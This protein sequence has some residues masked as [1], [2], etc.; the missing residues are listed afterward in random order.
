MGDGKYYI[1]KDGSGKKHTVD[2]A[3]YDS[4][5]QG[6]AK[7]FPNARFE[8][9]DR[10]TG[11]RGD[12][13]VR[14]VHRLKDFGANLFTGRR[15]YPNSQSAQ[16]QQKKSTPLGRA[17]QS[18]AAEKWG[19]AENKPFWETG[20]KPYDASL[21]L[22]KP[23]G[24]KRGQKEQNG[25]LDEAAWDTGQKESELVRG[26]READA[27]AR[28]DNEQMP[29]DYTK[30]TAIKQMAGRTK[31]NQQ[32]LGRMM[33]SAGQM[34]ASA[35]TRRR[36]APAFDTGNDDVNNNIVKTR[37]QLEKEM[38]SSAANIADND[39]ADTFASMIA[40]E[41]R[42][43]E[44]RAWKAQM[45]AQAG[46]GNPM[47]TSIL[48]T[49][50][51]NAQRDPAKLQQNLSNT[52]AKNMESMLGDP[53]VVEKIMSESAR[54]GVSP[55]DYAKTALIPA[56][57]NK[58]MAEYDKSELKE[59]M[60]RNAF[61]DIID[62][63][64]DSF[65]GGALL[66]AMTTKA[67]RQYRQRAV[68]ATEEG[69]NPY[70]QRDKY[71]VT[72]ALRGGVGLMT[73]VLGP[74]GGVFGAIGKGV[75]AAGTRVFG[76]GV[77]AAA[78]MANM[79]RMQRAFS[80]PILARGA[81]EGAANFGLYE[82]AKGAQSYA[83][84]TDD[85]RLGEMLTQSAASAGHGAVS[86]ATLG[87]VGKMLG[88]LGY[89]VGIKG[90][91]DPHFY[92]NMAKGLGMKGMQVVGEG[93]AF[94]VGGNI[95]N[96]ISGEKMDWGGGN[97]LK[98]II[99]AGVYKLTS[100]HTIKGTVDTLTPKED[101]SYKGS[102]AAKFGAALYK[103]A[104]APSVQGSRFAF[105]KDEKKQ[106]FDSGDKAG[107]QGKEGYIGH[108]DILT[109]A[110]RISQKTSVGKKDKDGNVKEVRK[111]Y[112]AVM[113]DPTVSW[114]AKMKVNALLGIV[115]AE[116]PMMDFNT[117]TTE[118]D[119]RRYVNEYAADGTLLSKHSY[120]NMDERDAIE[121][122]LGALR[123][124]QRMLNSLGSLVQ[125]D[126]SRIDLQTA[127]LRQHGYD[128]NNPDAPANRALLD[129]ME[130]KAHGLKIGN[131]RS[132]REQWLDF[133]AEKGQTAKIVID[134]AKEYGMTVEEVY[135]A[136]KKE[137]LKRSDNEQQMCAALRRNA[138]QTVY[139]Q[140]G[141]HPE[142]SEQ[143]GKDVVEENGLGTENPNSQAVVE[144]MGELT[145]AEAELQKAMDGDDTFKQ[146]Y[147]RLKKQG[148]S[149]AQIYQELTNTGMT[150]E[151]LVPLANYIN[152]NAK[153]Q[154][155]FRGTQQK[156]EETV[157][158]RVAD[159]S[160][161]GTLNGDKGN[162]ES[163]VYVTDK[164]GRTLIVGAGD[165]SFGEDGRATEGDM[166]TVLDP[167]TGEMDF[168]SVKDVQMDHIEKAEDYANAFRQKLQEINSEGYQAAAEQQ[169]EQG[170]Q[171]ATEQ[172]EKPATEQTTA[173]EGEQPKPEDNAP[174]FKDGTPV[175]MTKDSKGRD[176][177]D[178]SKMTPEQGAEYLPMTFGENA[179][180]VVD[181]KIK[182]AE[183]AVKTAEKTNV[184]YNADDAD[185]M[186]AE[187]KKK[188]ALEAAQ[189]ELEYFTA[190]KNM[191]KQAKA[192]ESAGGEGLTGNK[193]EQWRKDGYHIGEGGVR[194][195]RQKKEDMKGVYG[196]EVKVDF[197]PTVSVKGRAKV[198]EID[199]VQASHVNGQVN[200]MHFGLDWQPKDRTDAASKDGQDKALTNFD[201][202]KITGDG[203]AFIGSSP[204]VDERHEVIQGNNR[205]EIL[206]RLY[207]EYPEKAAKYKQWLIDHA[208]DFGYDPEEIAKMKRPVLVNELPVDDATAK[209]LGQYRA[210]DFESGGKEI[211]RASVVIN[212][213]GDKMQ[214]VA[215]ILLNQG[216]LPDD[217]K[218]NDLMAQNASRV[219]DYLVKEGVITTTEEQT[220]RKD[221]TTL[222]QWMAELLRTG[223]FDGDKQMEAAFN[224]LPDNARK[225][226]LAT[227]MRDAKSDDAAKIKQNLQHS[228]EAYTQMMNDPAFV[229]AKNVAEARAAIAAEI[230]KGN[231]SLFGE[232]PV[233]EKF[234]NFELELAALYKG[235]K[236]QK[237]LTGL[238]NKYFDVVQGDM[239]TGR[240]LEIGEEPREAISK[241]AA[242]KEV[243][244]L[245]DSKPAETQRQVGEALKKIATEITKQTGI[246]VVTDENVG[247]STLEDAE[248]TDSNVKFH[249]ETDEDVLNALNSGET[250]KV[251]RAM[252]VID[253]KLYPPMAASVGG[254][255]V[256]ANELGVW[257]R[258]D[259]NPD[260]AIP[261]ID[262][263]TGKQKVD[264]NT[265]EL[266]WKFKLDKGGKDATGKKA[267]DINAAYN[268]YWHMSR[269]PLNDQ[270][271]SA[272]IRPNIVVVECEIPVSELTS[273]YKAERAKDAV[274][275]V[276]WKSGSVSGEVFKQTGRARKVIL[277][278]WCKPVRVLSD[279]E[280]A[281]K[282]KEFVGE[283]KVEIPENVLTPK[284]RIAF[285]E[286]GFKIGAPEKGVKKSE[287][288]LEALEKGLQIDNSVREQRASAGSTVSGMD[289]MPKNL[290][291]NPTVLTDQIM[292]Y[293]G[294]HIAR[295][296]DK[297]PEDSSVKYFSAHN[298]VWYFYRVDHDRNIILD[299]A[300]SANKDNYREYEQKIKEYYGIDGSAEDIYSNLQKI[301]YRTGASRDLH[302]YFISEGNRG[303]RHMD[304]RADGSEGETRNNGSRTDGRN[305]RQ[306]T[307]KEQSGEFRFFRSK[308]GEVYGFTLAEKIYLDTKKMK[309][310]TPLHEYAHLWS[311]ALRCANPKEWEH[312]KGLFDKVDG[313]KEEV[314]KLYPELEGD[315][316]YEEMI[317][318]FSG[319]EG[320]KKLEDVVRKL[321]AEDGKTV[322]ESTKA[323][324]FID[325]V[326]TAL[327]E[328]WKGVADLLHI[329]FTTAE[330]V[331]DKVLADWANGIDPRKIAGEKKPEEKPEGEKKP[332]TPIAAEGGNKP[333]TPP[334]NPMEGMKTAAEQYKEE[335]RER[336]G[337]QKEQTPEEK[338]AARAKEMEEN[339]LTT[340]EI[341]SY[342]TGD[343]DM[344]TL[345]KDYAKDYLDGDKNPTTEFYYNQIYENVRN[346]RQDG[347]GDSSPADPP[348]V[349]GGGDE[350]AQS[351]PDGGGAG[352]VGGEPSGTDVSGQ[353]PGEK[354]GEDSTAL[355][356]GEG[357]N[358]PVG[359]T[360]STVEGLPTRSG[361]RKRGGN[362]RGDRATGGR[363]GAAPNDKGST[364][365]PKLDAKTK[366]KQSGDA[367]KD[368][369]A[370][371][372]A[373]RE[374]NRKNDAGKMNAY[375][376]LTAAV[377]G[378]LSKKMLPRDKEEM[379]LYGQLIKACVEHAYDV[380]RVYGEKI[381]NWFKGMHDDLHDAIK[382]AYGDT[383]TDEDV[384]N[385]I[386]SL[387]NTKY[388]I[389]GKRQ[390]IEKWAAEIGRDKLRAALSVSLEEKRKKQQEAE[391]VEVKVGDAENIAES[392]PFL[393]P[394]QQNDVLKAETQF[395][396][397]KHADDAH[398]NGRGILFT[399][400]TGTGKTY[401]GLGIA[402]RFIKQG[403]GRVL[404]VTPSPA[405]V[406][407]WSND[408]K[409]LGI[410]LTPLK[411]ESGKGATMQKGEGAVVTTFA[412]FRQNRALM[413]DVFDLV[414]YDESHK[415]MENRQ[416]Q[417]SATTVAHYRMTNKDFASAMERI[418]LSHPLWR[419]GE[420]LDAEKRKL[421]NGNASIDSARL[422]PNVSDESIKR[423]EQIDKR[424]A[425]IEQ[426]KAKAMPE[427]TK[428]AKESV[429]KTKVVFLSATPFNMRE[430]LE[431]AE[432]YLFKYNMPERPANISEKEWR[433][434]RNDARNQFYRQWFPHGERIGKSGK[435][436]PFVSD[437]D[438]NDVEERS[439]ADHL[440]DLGV[441]S[442]RTIDNGYDYSRDFPTVSV[443]HADRFNTA[444]RT[445]MTS[446]ILRSVAEQVFNDYNTMSVIYETMKA[447]ACAERIKEHLCMGRK[448]VVFHR[449]VNDRKGLAQP[450]F[451]SVMK[452]A[453]LYA[454]ALE[455][456]GGGGKAE[457]QRVRMAMAEFERTY[458]DL[459]QWEQTLDYRMP[460]QQIASLLGDMHNYTPEEMK[461][462]NDAEA[463]LIAPAFKGNGDPYKAGYEFAKTCF[464]LED[465]DVVEMYRP[466]EVSD[467]EAEMLGIQ[468]PSKAQHKKEMDAYNAIAKQVR[469]G[470]EDN[471]RERI[472]S[473]ELKIELDEN[474]KK[475][476]HVGMSAGADSTSAK[477]E[478]MKAFNSDDSGMDVMV[479]QE[480]SGKEGI[481]LHDTTGKHQRVMMNLALPQSP[482]AFI[483]AEGRIYR[484]GQK[485]NAIFEYPL[486]GID[487]E[488]SLFAGRFNGRAATTEN[489]ALGN[490][491]RGLKDAIMRGVLTKRGKVPL[492]GQ[493]YGGREWDMRDDQRA[494]GYDGA[495]R[496]WR[497]E[498]NGEQAGTID[499]MD[500]PQPLGFKL[501]EW[502][503]TNEGETVL[504]PS[505]GNGNVS[506][507]LPSNAKS[508]SIEPDPKKYNN[509]MLITGGVERG[510]A[511]A[512][513][514]RT[515]TMNGK[516][517]DLSTQSKF[518][519][520]IMN[521][522]N[523]AEGQT[524]KKHLELAVAHLNDSGRIVAV[525][526]ETENMEK[527]VKELV[528]G[529]PS[530]RVTGEVKLPP[531]AYSIGGVSQKA[532]VVTIDKLTREEMRKNWKETQTTDLSDITDIETLVAKLKNV[533]MP[534]RV[535][536]PAAKDIR[537]ANMLKTKLERIDLFK[538]GKSRWNG[539]TVT[540][541]F[542]GINIPTKLDKVLSS[543]AFYYK[544]G[545]YDYWFSPI[546]TRNM[547]YSKIKELDPFVLA[548]YKVS[549]EILKM[550]D[551]EIRE[552]C[553][554]W[555]L[556]D[557]DAPLY[558][559]ALKQYSEAMMK[560]IRGI[561]GRTDTQ[562]LRA[563]EG[564]D[565]DNPVQVK[566]GT[567]MSAS[568][569]KALFEANNENEE[570][571]TLFNRVYDTA[572][573][574]GLKIDVFDDANTG[575]SAYYS[576]KN[577]IRINASHWNAKKM[578]N[579]RGQIVPATKAVRAEV[580]CHE[581]IHS[582]T[583]YANY[584]YD[585]DPSR[586][587][588]GLRDAAKELDDIYDKIIGSKESYRI[589]SYAKE[590]K[591]E[592]V[593]EMANPAVREPLKKMGLWTRLV[594]AVK[595]FF[596]GEE[597]QAAVD[598][599]FAKDE[600]FDQSTVY[601]ELSKTLD[602]FLNN[603][604]EGSYDAYIA[605]SGA[606]R[607]GKH[608]RTGEAANNG[609]PVERTVKRL[610]D[611][612]RKVAGK[613]GVKVNTIQTVEEISDPQV[614]KDIESGKA[615]QGWYD[616]KTGEVHLYMPNIKCSRDAMKTVWH[617]TVGHKGMRGLLGDKFQDYMR[618]LWMDLDSPANAGL[619]EYV[620]GRM[621]K[622]PL[623]MYDA[624]EEYIADAAE[625]GKGEPGFWLNIKNKVADALH[626]IGYRIQPNVKDVK[627]MLWL[628]KNVQKHP[629]DPVW[630]MRAEAVKWKIEYDKFEGTKEHGG[631]LY[632]NDG[633]T[634]DLSGMS[635]QEW[636]EAT[637][638]ETHYRTAPGAATALDR[639]HR[640]LNAHSYMATEAFMD[641]MLSLK[642]LMQ[643]IA[644][645]IKKIEDI[646]SSENPYMLHNTM[647]GAACDKMQ[648]FEYDV[649]QPLTKTVA[650]AL[651]AVDGKDE[652]ER[653]RNFN[654]YMIKKHGLE[655]NRVFFVRDHIKKMAEDEADTLQAEWDTVKKD[656]GDKLRKGQIDL[657]EYYAQTDEWIRQNVD[658]DY[659]AEEHDYSGMHGI[660]GIINNKDPYDDAAAI[661]DV[662]G[663]ERS[664]E[665]MNKGS[666]D[667]LWSKIKVATQYAL[668]EDYNNGFVTKRNHDHV[669][670][671]FDWYVPLRKFDEN[672]AEDVYG[673]V[674]ENGESN[675]YL[676]PTL[677]AAKGRKSLSNV[678]I[679]AQIGTMG[680]H[681]ISRGAQNLV[682]MAFA[683]FVRNNGG[684]GLVKE[685]K[686]WVELKGTDKNGNGIWE[687]VYP[688]I[689]EGATGD[690]MA[691]IVEQ[692]EADMEAKKANGEAK[693]ISDRGDIGFKFERAKNRNE[694]FVDVMIAGKRHRF[695]V[696]GNPR[697]AQALNGLLV[698]EGATTLFGKGMKFVTRI[699]GQMATSFAPEFV[700]RNVLRD[701]QMASAHVA[702]KEGAVYARKWLKYYAAMNPFNGTK[703]IRLSDFK[704][705]SGIGLYARYRKGQ[706]DMNN[707]IEKWFK[708]FMENGG[709][710]GWVQMK[711]MQDFEKEYSDKVATERSALR[712]SGKA[713]AD[714]FL[715]NV[716]RLNEV[717][718]NMA[719]FA[720]YCA[721][722]E[723]GRGVVR[724]AYDAKEVS[725]N[726]NR[727]GSGSAITTF[728]N[729]ETGRF[730]A[731]RRN[732]YGYTSS[733]LQNYSMF[734]NAAIQS[735]NLLVKNAKH[736]PVATTVEMGSIPFGLGIVAA[737]VNNA[738]I[739]GEDEKKRGGVKDPYAELPD[740]IRRNNLCIYKGK[741]EFVTV[742]LAI[743]LR[744]FYGM[745]DCVAGHTV[746][747]NIESQRNFA[748]DMA[749]CASQLLPV[750]DF[751]NTDT[752]DKNPVEETV[753][754]IAPTA[755]SSAVIEWWQN[756]DW[757]GAPIRRVGDYTKNNPA[758]KNAYNGTPEA[759][760]RLNKWANATTNDVAKGNENMKGSDIADFVTDPSL[761]NHIYSTL[762]GGLATFAA[763]TIGGTKRLME[764]KKD[765]IE[766]K[767]IP[768]LRSLMYT[769][770]EQSSM[771]RTKAKWYSY[772]D[773][774][775]KATAN[776]NALKKKNVPLTERVR[777]LADMH[778]FETSNKA[779]KIGI[780]KDAE[781]QMTPWKKMKQ[782][783]ADDK[784]QVDFANKQ[785][786]RIMQKA[787]E[788]LD[789]T[790]D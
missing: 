373:K 425:E 86:G 551:A 622:E 354:G 264:K 399:N 587:P 341:D 621:A 269:S 346:R 375:P 660:Q 540:D 687:E 649:M 79:T 108:P 398:G 772:K 38:G 606:R 620:R 546:T 582:V 117:Y 382:D 782:I 348:H 448:V 159:W 513:G 88:G 697:A 548:Q 557:K 219:L 10:K 766:T 565:I 473:G 189:K 300:I 420:E 170:E 77:K 221:G 304:R 67:Q 237:T 608:F 771:A 80:L 468:K 317:T 24:L 361:G 665:G 555:R 494:T 327:K 716:E 281:Q 577:R 483:Q 186:E 235:L 456:S 783:N 273:G 13:D 282:A 765:E 426:E 171:P 567:E 428:K 401:T 444:V 290:R 5:P 605:L 306:N 141:A 31:R 180:K 583:S 42:A 392:L 377:I 755:V 240:Q 715:G 415:L 220:L 573:N 671:M 232:E 735:T 424:L 517:E 14:N 738:L 216:S 184:D 321:A 597:K 115:P 701:A 283:A 646:Q 370:K 533:A 149:N 679:L 293:H 222:R 727:H 185:I 453:G 563:F 742:P 504:E 234:S 179:G 651:D 231:E 200:P 744:A 604:D 263:K 750:V 480:A 162:G 613:L 73:D 11:R 721:S 429:G 623:S 466:H 260:L 297:V 163:M 612:A 776:Y 111:Y 751:M 547:R 279:A 368:L 312:V 684:Q 615:V 225:A 539:V 197:S 338:A 624:I 90:V 71:G 6:F 442:G 390:T 343:E 707:K 84:T 314:K 592:L 289:N 406:Q 789:K 17:Q 404:I 129:E 389:D 206:R 599:G 614:R 696:L 705:D 523:G 625:N 607:D 378:E 655:R 486:L 9:I 187:A 191:M 12:V 255:L 675:T 532:R 454:A 549:S 611:T 559:D 87:V 529:N 681:A 275:E 467:E 380:L 52:L 640:Q 172:E 364:G 227:Y 786:E 83:S 393:L 528:E 460:R 309:P 55:E 63:I 728:K 130:G 397:P 487:N 729:G 737:L 711:S 374:A 383:L 99:A 743:E 725:T 376:G 764:G 329:H 733:F 780:I 387:W 602:K 249:K 34:A 47:V 292:N 630:K 450:P 379:A 247:Q 773:E 95:N 350:P 601:N 384:D 236:D 581:L 600:D 779:R 663:V 230:E 632:E 196:R 538:S 637:D 169:A 325:R 452:Q 719:R 748:M 492:A 736:A 137:P 136:L 22:S 124:N 739:A 631:E 449:R 66:S 135:K 344:D 28:R 723:S 502:A 591:N 70:Y 446:Q 653:M 113:N 246:E 603:F 781:R 131:K 745:G 104:V 26:L 704:G 568:D 508:L 152:A 785:M 412:N 564:E 708:E 367:V 503:K 295:L 371:I 270:F 132:L 717:A 229:N 578:V 762:G 210:S 93:A 407:D 173:N 683:R 474:G 726:F 598:A 595:K 521:S 662:M 566:A 183:A 46:T 205:A 643:A 495:V 161:K 103:A 560:A 272:W 248:A 356:D 693:S 616:E 81:A 410:I 332:E 695:V 302:E 363:L 588:D 590:N 537:H 72:E 574:L 1:F 691:G 116:R 417:E 511:E 618:G 33:E 556:K 416:A 153:A 553:F 349:D 207:D 396:D 318:T 688:D 167:Q 2:K 291:M 355:P 193:Y 395:F 76:N 54:L 522:P 174:K 692:F 49:A 134:T 677:M 617:E 109:W 280:V 658:K 455:M 758:W 749:G 627:Y 633:K 638:G 145:K 15:V 357:G 403:K 62:G 570:L 164:K 29:I 524:A 82:G 709:E 763:R 168:V 138:E 58:L 133:V 505:A 60:P 313:L 121:Y 718:E 112:E 664:M 284:Q 441:M 724:S 254:K 657:A 437:A 674:T 482:I 434:M 203:N 339:P 106:L 572:K 668:N 142:H 386:R 250:I 479:V 110:K 496:D 770:T 541:S 784:K 32:T 669:S 774:L 7:A 244:G 69:E 458:A 667:E 498:N 534:D 155:M 307:G 609:T 644:P 239:A 228:F 515:L 478:D 296:L 139:E 585:H 18:V 694:H 388:T 68:M 35:E 114:D 659:K 89:N 146:E 499:D 23:R 224:S 465:A 366:A 305:L 561:S 682:K 160:Y 647:Q 440:M 19:T 252:Q 418:Q 790:G 481:S 698:N 359:G 165:V 451:A 157:Q 753:K 746:A 358:K 53:N 57:S 676:G 320:A 190:V 712:K 391:K 330:E 118:E 265:G 656:L 166:L 775:E 218:L 144:T 436:E 629:N 326:K 433:A 490:M 319:R 648:R 316:L 741:G 531:C 430:N 198:V 722:R 217:A 584:W 119:G 464:D 516:F 642:A 413:E 175:P 636:L 489:L 700:M 747:K 497:N 670:E 151:K 98:N 30:Q 666:V 527:F 610:T 360:T 91:N 50:A 730:K 365:T 120:R 324:G 333:E 328:Y 147:E 500:T 303:D 381:E 204:S 405:K 690:Q 188:A 438:K 253:G 94:Y 594:N 421:L 337:Q 639:Y 661:D 251:Y 43:A 127:F 261:D 243:F 475:V 385:Y 562:L 347:E 414:I 51:Y 75:G 226:V 484:I 334:T 641:N 214:S 268:P 703:N 635:K 310:E 734:F 760:M 41:R 543:D 586:L 143:Q 37:G 579:E 308:N 266:K 96:A 530:L 431:Y 787:V 100:T 471:I 558:I 472:A 706:L 550:S 757:K 509:L 788:Q 299:D 645:K 672:T 85:A 65:I 176:T 575:T 352:P 740:Y 427:L 680:N 56:I 714:F 477:L 411:G 580:L 761:L 589:P 493:G 652:T 710:T 488:I 267:T 150:Q 322:T 342:S 105:T 476:R 345:A 274:G 241:E 634:H 732:V 278:R 552:K 769:P 699:M 409:N 78:Q 754:G 335:Q 126:C 510:S 507:Y 514:R 593:A 619:R 778:R 123:E 212:R 689:P 435:V 542:F 64:G 315:D 288:I 182:K 323:Q 470:I 92:R 462:R 301:G 25:G 340:E 48:G 107:L 351:G 40:D 423:I 353:L 61:V 685:T 576:N 432:G 519:T 362:T 443:T 501:A 178:Y 650:K 213:L 571:S 256:E 201:A 544:I 20:D 199:S 678:N 439:F 245:H 713:L 154:G 731:A 233:R 518:D 59:W 673:Y 211:P 158:K 262:P 294:D 485:S 156:I 752:Y 702:S 257:I 74:G 506:R 422:D 569:Y 554:S 287:Q 277:S 408:A 491:A 45:Q 298:G 3:A 720:T 271:K 369:L 215:N 525:L 128:F 177:A 238:L 286:A 457:A 194:Y 122:R 768:F 394:E 372:K 276:D 36:N 44:S 285:E 447:S 192:E 654:L 311:A 140:G 195:D 242:L 626:E 39:F 208:K 259:E 16:T 596:M 27:M 102:V 777:N 526:P 535:L 258:A 686:V 469:K 628:A 536:D 97:L 331:A 181:G 461:A 402:K 545:G 756:S 445:L 4:N 148:L 459:M 209:K 400:G 767:D 223:L 520:I 336:N 463:R 21:S 512:A 202:E 759:L 101:M 125:H 8:V 419:E